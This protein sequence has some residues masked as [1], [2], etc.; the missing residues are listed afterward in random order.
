MK[1]IQYITKYNAVLL[2]DIKQQMG[3]FD[4]KTNPPIL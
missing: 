4:I 1:N 2:Y 3:Q